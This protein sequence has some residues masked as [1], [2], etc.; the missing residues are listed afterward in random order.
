M[1]IKKVVLKHKKLLITS[2]VLALTV[3]STVD[4]VKAG[5]V[6]LEKNILDNEYTSRDDCYGF[7]LKSPFTKIEEYP[8]EPTY[9]AISRDNTKKFT[10]DK[11]SVR[12]YNYRDVKDNKNLKISADVSFRYRLDKYDTD[13]FRFNTNGMDKGDISSNI[14]YSIE[15]CINN[16]TSNYTL[17]ELSDLEGNRISEYISEYVNEKSGNYGFIIEDLKIDLV[18]IEGNRKLY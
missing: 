12:I 8:L 16:V 18:R 10:E 3:F 17:A 4:Y 6:G 5:Y 13:L 14:A 1:K 7:I 11:T 15:K 9:T 2:T